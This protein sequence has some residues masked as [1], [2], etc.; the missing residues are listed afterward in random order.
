[1][2]RV[3]LFRISMDELF[4]RI[5]EA[6]TE[7][8]ASACTLSREDELIY[9]CLHASKHG[10]LNSAGLR[11]ARSPEWF[12]RSITGNRLIW[13][14]DIHYLLAR[15]TAQLDWAELRQRAV[16]WNVEEEVR[17]TLRVVD[18]LLPGSQAERALVAMGSEEPARDSAPPIAAWS[19]LLERSMTMSQTLLFRPTRFLFI[20]RSFFPGRQRL[21]R[22]YGVRNPLKASLLAMLHPF[23]FVVR[24][25]RTSTSAG[26]PLPE[27]ATRTAGPPLRPRSG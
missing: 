7:D 22:F 23:V 14:L 12:C 21:M 6:D 19:A 1:V 13:F 5:T 2:D 11:A 17:D 25:L 8:G 16:A 27:I 10:L 9:L 20:G 24:L 18:R 26:S 3:N 4:Q 15:R